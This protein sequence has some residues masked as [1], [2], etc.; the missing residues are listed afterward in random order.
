MCYP[1]PLRNTFQGQVMGGSGPAAYNGDQSHE[2]LG[3]A[4]FH[5]RLNQVTPRC[6]PFN[7]LL[8]GC[9][10]VKILP[11]DLPLQQSILTLRRLKVLEKRPASLL[12]L[13]LGSRRE[14]QQLLNTRQTSLLGKSSPCQPYFLCESC[15]PSPSLQ[16]MQQM[17][18]YTP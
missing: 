9:S 6:R 12:R 13:L 1:P 7:A 8:E 2:T 11:R 18:C 10:A 14:E 3:S 16:P 4:G 17:L 15:F 5:L